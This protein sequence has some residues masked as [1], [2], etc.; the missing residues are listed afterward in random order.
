MDPVTDYAFHLSNG[1]LTEASLILNNDIIF[2]LLVIALVLIAEKRNPKRVKIFSAVL[3]AAIFSVALKSIFMV[4]RP[5]SIMDLD[6]CPA[7]YALPSLHAT[8]AFALMISFLNKRSYWVFVLFALFV[9]FSRLVLAVHTFRDIA[10]AL[11]VALVSYYIVA[12][13]W[14]K[15]YNEK[16]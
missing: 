12:V 4:E 10:A 7:D 16:D 13:L 5:C 3:L 9:S 1:P 8:V 2:A 14:R 11:P 6:Y 15:Y